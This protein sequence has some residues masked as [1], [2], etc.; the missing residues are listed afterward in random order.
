[1]PAYKGKLTGRSNQTARRLH[2]R[3]GQEEVVRRPGR[4]RPRLQFIRR[5]RAGGL[6]IGILICQI[7]LSIVLA[8]IFLVRPS[9]TTGGPGRSWPS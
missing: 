7:V 4:N 5:K 3:P 2:P 8:S 6:V 1:M 9:V